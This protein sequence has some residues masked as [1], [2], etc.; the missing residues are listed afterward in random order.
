MKVGDVYISINYPGRSVMV[1]EIFAETIYYRWD[2]S[3]K[4]DFN[5]KIAFKSNFR[6]LTKLE[7][8]LA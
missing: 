1:K 8:A 6:K 2:D 5:S 7:K 3:D 4:V